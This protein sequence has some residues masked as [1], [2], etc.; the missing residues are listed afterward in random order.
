M[1]QSTIRLAVASTLI[2]GLAGCASAGKKTSTSTTVSANPF[3]AS[4][5]KVNQD[6]TQT[7][8]DLGQLESQVKVGK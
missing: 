3:S 7:E 2:F 1:F 6:F 5:K 8:T 4:A